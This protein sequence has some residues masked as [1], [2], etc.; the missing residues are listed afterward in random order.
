[1][2]LLLIYYCYGKLK[3]YAVFFTKKTSKLTN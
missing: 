3:L 2:E 1:M